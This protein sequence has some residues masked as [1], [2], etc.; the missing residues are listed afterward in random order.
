[1]HCFQQACCWGP[2]A[3]RAS[4]WDKRLLAGLINIMHLVMHH[5]VSFV[6]QQLL[7][8]APDT[9]HAESAGDHLHFS[10]GRPMKVVK[11]SG[12]RNGRYTEC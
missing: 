11:H 6:R 10:R 12:Q 9:A 7:L 4:A 5:V 3:G 1:M 2:S 8:T